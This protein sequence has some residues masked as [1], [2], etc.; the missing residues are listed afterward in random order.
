M[1]TSKIIIERTTDQGYIEKEYTTEEAIVILN[2]ELEDGKTIF[3][4]STPISETEI[5]TDIL[6]RVRKKICVTNQL[7]GG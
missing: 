6:A 5:T 3:I 2:K 4:D 7:V 1:K